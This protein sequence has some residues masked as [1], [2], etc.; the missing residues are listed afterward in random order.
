MSNAIKYNVES[1]WIRITA[2]PEED[3]ARI[4]I[5]DGGIGMSPEEIAVLFQPY[6]RGKSERQIKGVGLGVVIVKKLVEAHGGTVEVV[7]EPGKGS[8]FTFNMPL[9]DETTP[10]DEHADL[11]LSH[12]QTS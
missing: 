1:G 11:D 5:A 2:R 6:T 7:S 9:A 10:L 3:W 12:Y 8:T 4:T